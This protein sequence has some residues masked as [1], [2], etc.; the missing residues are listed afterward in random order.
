MRRGDRAFHVLN[1]TKKAVLTGD[2]LFSQCF[3]IAADFTT[4]A[5]A[6]NIAF[7][8]ATLCSSEIRQ[9]LDK[10]RATRK[11]SPGTTCAR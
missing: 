3:R 10:F 4:P 9:D 1:G 8:V 2:W 11:G 6:R 5:N 7:V